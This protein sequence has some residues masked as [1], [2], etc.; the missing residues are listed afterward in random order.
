MGT[1]TAVGRVWVL[2]SKTGVW[3]YP[4]VEKHKTTKRT[5]INFWMGMVFWFVGIGLA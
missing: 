4:M 1:A 3:E 5:K 2:L